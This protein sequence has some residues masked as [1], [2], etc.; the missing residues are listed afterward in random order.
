MFINGIPV[1]LLTGGR[2]LLAQRK[3]GHHESR[4]AEATLGSMVIHHGLLHR[5]QAFTVCEVF[6]GNQLLAM[7]GAEE[8]NTAVDRAVDEA[9]SRRFGH[10]H[11]AGATVTGGAPLLGTA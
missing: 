10:H 2:G 5:V 6:H 11:G 9:L 4:R 1:L 8:G 7:E 3:E